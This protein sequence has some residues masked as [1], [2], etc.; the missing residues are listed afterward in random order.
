[1]LQRMKKK[2]PLLDR[3]HCPNQKQKSGVVVSFLFRSSFYSIGVALFS[4]PKNIVGDHDQYQFECKWL[5][6][7]ATILHSGLKLINL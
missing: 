2:K 3:R 7:V 5:V 6:L 1:M 4:P